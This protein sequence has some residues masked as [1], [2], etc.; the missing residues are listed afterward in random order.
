MSCRGVVA[1]AEPTAR[2][3][4]WLVDAAF[5][6]INRASIRRRSQKILANDSRTYKLNSTTTPHS[7]AKLRS[8]PRTAHSLQMRYL[9][10][11]GLPRQFTR[12][13]IWTSFPEKFPEPGWRPPFYCPA[14]VLP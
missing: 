7:P 14:K 11:A 4:K 8:L 3:R 6:Q 5:R 10:L 12:Q 1:A 13:R 2:L 9:G